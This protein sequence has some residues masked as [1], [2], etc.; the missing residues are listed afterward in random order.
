MKPVAVARSKER[1]ANDHF[2]FG[3]AAPNARHHGA[4]L[5]GRNNVNQGGHL[6]DIEVGAWLPRLFDRTRLGAVPRHLQ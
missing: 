6:L 3:V 4:S 2:G 5:F 1:L